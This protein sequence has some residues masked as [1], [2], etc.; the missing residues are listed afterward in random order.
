MKTAI[1][2]YREND[3]ENQLIAF[4]P[5]WLMCES[6]LARPGVAVNLLFSSPDSC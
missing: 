1:Q 2:Q 4:V 5:V 3:M 6:G